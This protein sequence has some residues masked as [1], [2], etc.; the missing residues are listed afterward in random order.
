[1]KS[2]DWKNNPDLKHN[3]ISYLGFPIRSFDGKPF[4]T[5]CLLDDKE[6]AHSADVADLMA[7]MRD[8]IESHL[9]LRERVWLQERLAGDSQLKT[10]LDNVPTAIAC[11][12]LDGDFRMVYVNREFVRTFGYTLDDI[13]TIAAWMALAYPDEEY[14]AARNVA[15]KASVERAQTPGGSAERREIRV[16]RKDGKPV[17]VIL[18]VAVL[19]TLTVVSLIDITERKRVEEE[20]R[21]S[22]ERFRL[23][24]D[25]A[26]DMISTMDLNGVYTYVSPSAVELSGYSQA[27]A[28]R[29][30]YEDVLT[31]G[32]LAVTADWAMRMLANAQAGLPFETFRGEL[33]MRRKDGSTVWTEAAVSPV[34]DAGATGWRC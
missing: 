21:V 4:G 15:W 18:A 28:M 11:T 32:S 5:I 9:R 12:T 19:E 22:E 17:D 25:N 3:L 2:D 26:A 1:M 31:P 13:P 33:E 30:K 27:E 10:L 20:L 23:M 8:L 29:L 14:R 24:A 6:N 16:T 34:F 7:R